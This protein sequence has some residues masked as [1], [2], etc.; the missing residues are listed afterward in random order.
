MEIKIKNIDPLLKKLKSSQNKIA[1]ERDKLRDLVEEYESLA[2]A[3]DEA[4][5]SI[6]AAIDSLST[7][8]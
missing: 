7:L 2:F 3:C 6:E 5:E 1:I 8:V 4:I